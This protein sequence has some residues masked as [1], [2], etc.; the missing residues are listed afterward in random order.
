MPSVT[1]KRYLYP[2]ISGWPW[3]LGL[4]EVITKRVSPVIF[5]TMGPKHIW[6][7]TST[8]LDHVTSSVRWPIDP[9]YVISYWCP[10]GTEPLSLDVSEIFSPKP[11]RAHTHTHRHTPQVILYSVPCN[12]LQ[13]AGKNYFRNCN[14]PYRHIKNSKTNRSIDEVS[15]WVRS[16][17]MEQIYP[18]KEAWPAE[19]C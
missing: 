2:N 6:V 10:T 11:V 8:F 7:T 16:I 5:K 19:C 15:L 4:H 17:T 18:G 12:V 3:P 1:L 9:P 14:V 13:W